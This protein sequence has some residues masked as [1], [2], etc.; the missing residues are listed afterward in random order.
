MK[1]RPVDDAAGA[2]GGAPVGDDDGWAGDAADVIAGEIDR[3]GPI[4]F[5]RYQH[6][7][8]YGPGG[9]YHAGGA[10]RAD[11][12]FLT[13]PEVGP[14]F[15]AVVANWLDDTWVD[16][17]RPDPFVVVEAGA[18]PGTLA[19][20]V[21][22]A[23]PRCA[24]ALRYVLV[25]VSDAQ[26]ARHRH[27]L[28]ITPGAEVFAGSARDADGIPIPSSVAGPLVASVPDLPRHI[29]AGVVVANELVDNLPVDLVER[30]NDGWLEVRVGHRDGRFAEVVVPAGDELARMADRFAPDAAAG[31]RVPLQR[32]ARAWLRGALDRLERGRVVM[33]DYAR[34]TTAEMAELDWRQWLRTYRRH[35]RA[36][37]VLE[38]PGSSDVTCDVAL[39]QLAAVAEPASAIPQAEW[40]RRGGIDDLVSEGR[41]VW[42]ERAGVGDLVALAARSRVNEAAALTDPDGLGGF[43]VVEWHR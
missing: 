18:G 28:P 36:G 13:S 30:G 17:G 3:H 23:S 24:A 41:R 8:L 43:A 7:A 40:L 25:E 29:E 34:P 5:A 37:S 14:L 10:G 39:D 42:S 12:D 22:A 21:L 16:L 32:A 6:L 4:G 11:R 20:A 31:A 33:I 19:V 1:D 2:P 38:L 35:Q 15:G 9:F 27:R 26:R